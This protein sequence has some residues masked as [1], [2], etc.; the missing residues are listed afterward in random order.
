M[1]RISKLLGTA[2]LGLALTAFVMPTNASAAGDAAA[3]KGIYDATC[4]LCHGPQ[5][6][7][8]GPGAT[9]LNPPPRNFQTGDFAFDADGDGTKGAD[10]DL[11][12]VIKD[13]AAKYGGSPVMT[14]FGHFSDADVA[15]L[16]AYIRS[17]KK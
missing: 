17:L 3:G 7:G 1:N 14:P 16:V 2:F 13:G 5:G 10:A 6:A 9:G 12:A 8:D 15:N 11:A 4:G